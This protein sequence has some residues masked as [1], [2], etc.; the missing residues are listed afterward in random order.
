MVACLQQWGYGAF[1]ARVVFHLLYPVVWLITFDDLDDVRQ[2][3]RAAWDVLQVLEPSGLARWVDEVI[4]IYDKG[5]ML[6]YDPVLGRHEPFELASHP[7][8]DPLWPS[9]PLRAC[10]TGPPLRFAS[11]PSASF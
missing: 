4:V 9:A 3:L 8:E 6:F 1:D 2:T 11:C 10:H 5:Q 7:T